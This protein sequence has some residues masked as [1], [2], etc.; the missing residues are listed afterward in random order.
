MSAKCPYCGELMVEGEA[1]VRG[2]ILGFLFYGFSRQHLWFRPDHESAKTVIIESGTS[3][4]GHQCPSCGAVSISRHR[5]H[6]WKEG[7]ARPVDRF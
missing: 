1:F 4:A 3:R 5:K 2:T 7:P 6:W